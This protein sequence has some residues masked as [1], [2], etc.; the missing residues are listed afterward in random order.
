MEI[1]IYILSIYGLA[2]AIKDASGPWG[3][4]SLIRNRLISNKYVGVFFFELF[5][6]YFCVGFHAGWIVYLLSQDSWALNYFILWALA[7]GVVSLILDGAVA[8]LHKQ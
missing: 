3:I 4:M 7:G 5:E 1:I 8:Q 2:F 6:C